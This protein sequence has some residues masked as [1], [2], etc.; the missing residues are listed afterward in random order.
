MALWWVFVYQPGLARAVILIEQNG[1]RNANPSR[2]NLVGRAQQS[3]PWHHLERI[4]HHAIPDQQTKTHIQGLLSPEGN[5]EE[6]GS[7]PPT[8][9]GMVSLCRHWVLID[10]LPSSRP[11][12]KFLV[13]CLAL[14]LEPVNL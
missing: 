3:Q 13:P 14:D 4:E 12:P 11:S 2:S 1:P 9:N 7:T 6:G 8:P 5:M 10:R